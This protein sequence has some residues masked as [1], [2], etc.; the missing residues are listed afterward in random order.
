MTWAPPVIVAVFALPTMPRRAIL[1]AAAGA[2]VSLT[3]DYA[4][5]RAT[6]P[7][8]Y[9]PPPP[10]VMVLQIAENADAMQGIMAQV[11]SDLDALSLQQ[12]ITAGRPPLSRGEFD[13]NIDAM[14]AKS[15]KESLRLIVDTPTDT[16]RGVKTITAMGKGELSRD[17]YLVMAKQYSRARDELRAAFRGLPE[18]EQIL[19]T[20][21]NIGL[22][23]AN[24]YT[25]EF[26]AQARA[27]EDE[28]AKVRLAR[29]RIAQE[30]A[31]MPAAGEPPKRKKTLAELEAANLELDEQS[32]VALYAR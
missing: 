18:D 31:R 15:K 29:A 20:A 4:A 26:Y 1:G 2:M 11:A 25:E 24:D 16:L 3:P 10:G 8:G 13:A 27:L 5:A 30:N 12:R 19:A 22:Q 21:F 6:V 23:T 17:E 32:V 28:A 9:R 7:L 14:L